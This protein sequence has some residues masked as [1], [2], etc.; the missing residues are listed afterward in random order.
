MEINDL[1]KNP[2][3]IK[4]LIGALQSLLPKETDNEVFEQPKKNNQRN[5]RQR[6]KETDTEN[7]FL[8]MAEKNMHKEDI[9]VDKL[10][11]K[12]PPTPRTRK[13]T[14]VDVQCRQCGKKEKVNPSLV[15][16]ITRYKCNS[17]STTSN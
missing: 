2:E 17:C 10:L 14:F 16:D 13:F 1:L 9:Q 3:S 11:N 4:Q 7:K 6:V 12:N 15:H 8:K 5:K